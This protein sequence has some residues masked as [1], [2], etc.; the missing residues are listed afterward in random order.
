MRPQILQWTK[1]RLFFSEHLSGIVDKRADRYDSLVVSP[2]WFEPGSLARVKCR[3]PNSATDQ[4]QVVFS[5]HSGFHPAMIN[6]QINI[7]EYLVPSTAPDYFVLFCCE[8]E[9]R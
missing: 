5:G 3:T 1:V 7:S 6:G 9:W 2:L 8:V 4:G